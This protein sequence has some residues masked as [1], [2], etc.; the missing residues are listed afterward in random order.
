[1]H[2]LD[3]RNHGASPWADTMTYA[4]MAADVGDYIDAPPV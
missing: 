3:L 2:A 1:V 4:E